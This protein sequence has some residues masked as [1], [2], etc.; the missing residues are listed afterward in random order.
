MGYLEQINELL[1]RDTRLANEG[2][3]CATI[4][5][6]VIGDS[7]CRAWIGMADEHVT[8]AL[9]HQHETRLRQGGTTGSSRDAGSAG[10]LHHH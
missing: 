6:V 5:F 4:Q 2:A 7:D 8:P 9:T 1:D 10:I 3:E